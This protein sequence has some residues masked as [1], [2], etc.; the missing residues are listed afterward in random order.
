MNTRRAFLRSSAFS[1]VGI[2]SQIAI[3]TPRTPQH[4]VTSLHGYALTNGATALKREDGTWVFWVRIINPD[5]SSHDIKAN[6]QIATDRSFSQIVDV[7]P[8]TLTQA[9][10]FIAQPVYTPKARNT[11]LYYRYVIDSNPSVAPSVSSVVNSIAPWNTV[12][13]AE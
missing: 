1:L 11:Q 4:P 5:D 2:A 7:L 6:L 12:S 3:A 8:V 10:S 9:K 13:K